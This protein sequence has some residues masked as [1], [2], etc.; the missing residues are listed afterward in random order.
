LVRHEQI[1]GSGS[2]APC[3]PQTIAEN[4][5]FYNGWKFRTK[6]L[7]FVKKAHCVQ[8]KALIIEDFLLASRAVTDKLIRKNANETIGTH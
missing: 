8:V 2:A 6:R 4:G 7:N 1:K 5:A 3:T